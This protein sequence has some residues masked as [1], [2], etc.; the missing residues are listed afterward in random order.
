MS[1][2]LGDV[3]KR[4]AYVNIGT[5]QVHLPLV[6]GLLE[7]TPEDA[8]VMLL[9]EHRGFYL[10]RNHVIGTPVFQ[11]AG[12]S[13]PESFSDPERVMELLQR[14]RIT[15]VVMTNAP[16]GPDQVP[17]WFERLDPLL[18]GL[19]QCKQTGRLHPLWQ[20]ERYILL[21]VR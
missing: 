19:G 17:G 3:Y 5:D 20:S 2:G 11:E 7:H 1:R 9:F 10:P 15:H 6:Q 18:L 4:Q 13:P 16:A 21:E 14:H 8:R 12:F